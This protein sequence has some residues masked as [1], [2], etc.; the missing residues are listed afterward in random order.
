MPCWSR[1]GSPPE[2]SATGGGHDPAPSELADALPAAAEVAERLARLVRD[3]RRLRARAADRAQTPSSAVSAGPIGGPVA[4]A[5]G[6][7]RDARAGDPL[8]AQLGFEPELEEAGD[9]A[10]RARVRAREMESSVAMARRSLA[11]ATAARL[12]AGAPEARTAAHAAGAVTVEGPRGPLQVAVEAE[13]GSVVV[14]APGAAETLALAGESVRGLEL[15]SAL[16]GIASFDLS[17]W[18]LGG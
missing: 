5:A 2:R 10:A 13:A 18:R 6:V 7:S 1:A 3:S 15:A 16:T 17:P 12:D 4:R 9:A 8:Y 11:M 14:S